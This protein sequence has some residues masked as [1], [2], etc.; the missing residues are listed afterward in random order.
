MLLDDISICDKYHTNASKRMLLD[1]ISICVTDITQMQ[2]NIIQLLTFV[3]VDMKCD[4]FHTNAS[5]QRMLLYK[6]KIKV[7][8]LVQRLIT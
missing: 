5:K 1:D 6:I 4:Q 2:V 3:E 8:S 7:I